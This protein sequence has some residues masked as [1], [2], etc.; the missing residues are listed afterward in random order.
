MFFP[1]I[2]SNTLDFYLMQLDSCIEMKRDNSYNAFINWK[3]WQVTAYRI[4][5]LIA[6]TSGSVQLR[7]FSRLFRTIHCSIRIFIA[8]VY[9]QVIA[10]GLPL[11]PVKNS[12]IV[13][14]NV[15]PF[16]L[17]RISRRIRY[18]KKGK[19]KGRERVNEWVRVL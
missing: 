8:H 7:R 9:Q 18:E 12:P 1:S 16:A 6:S 3:S 4:D 11:L 10:V 15:F 19:K 13:L 5:E 14:A 2:Y 17:N